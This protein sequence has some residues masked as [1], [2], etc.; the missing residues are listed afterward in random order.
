MKYLY[1]IPLLFALNSYSQTDSTTN[2]TVQ[3]KEDLCLNVVVETDKFT[4]EISYNSP[5][6]ENISFIKYKSK[7]ITSQYVSLSI[8]DSY[9]AGYDNNGLIILFKS[10]KKISRANE[11]IDVNNSTGG[12]WR[13]SAFFT[14]TASEINLLKSEEIIGFKLYIFNSDLTEGNLIKTYANCVLV[15]PKVPV[16]KK[17]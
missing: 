14:P 5:D 11:K 1:L 10:G 17:K 8:Y 7:G 9:L 3:P 16:K 6:I 15:S 2:N 13:Y 4:G 12:N